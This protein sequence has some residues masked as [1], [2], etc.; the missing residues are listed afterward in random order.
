MKLVKNKRGLDKIIL[1]DIV[2]KIETKKN[3]HD[4]SDIAFFYYHNFTFSKS[5]LYLMNPLE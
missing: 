1:K 2:E 4:D 5:Y 3:D